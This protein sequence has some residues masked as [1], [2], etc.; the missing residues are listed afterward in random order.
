MR[1]QDGGL[2][3]KYGTIKYEAHDQQPRSRLSPLYTRIC[4]VQLNLLLKS[5]IRC[6]QLAGITWPSGA[7]GSA[8]FRCASDDNS[9][10]GFNGLVWD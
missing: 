7:A 8:S 5:D 9:F 2:T 10:G 1:H 4:N 3:N 6:P